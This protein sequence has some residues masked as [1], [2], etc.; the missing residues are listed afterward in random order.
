VQRVALSPTEFTNE[1]RIWRI[2]YAYQ[3]PYRALTP[4]ANECENLLVP[5]AASY[6]HVAFCTYR[7]ESVWM[8]AGHAAGTAA[9]L[10]ARDNKA[11]QSLDIAALQNTLRA[12][13]QVI[14]FVAGQPEKFQDGEG[15]YQEF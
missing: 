2:S 13:K 4:K 7:L 5:G 8:I 1:G 15:G 11:V 3:I 9:A 12:A 14:D 6:S 10:A